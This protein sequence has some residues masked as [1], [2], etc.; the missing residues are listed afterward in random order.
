MPND[1]SQMIYRYYKI[2]YRRD[3]I[4]QEPAEKEN[5]HEHSNK[6]FSTINR[7]VSR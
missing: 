7:S 3:V 2:M 4:E 1:T 6:F 5:D